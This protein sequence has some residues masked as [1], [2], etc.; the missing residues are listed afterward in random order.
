MQP[1]I[2][3]FLIVFQEQQGPFVNPRPMKMNC[4]NSLSFCLHC[5]MGQVMYTCINAKHEQSLILVSINLY[6]QE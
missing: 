5:F 2:V 6:T 4:M 3:W 1:R